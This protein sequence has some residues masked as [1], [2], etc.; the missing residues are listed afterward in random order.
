M[1][2]AKPYSL[3][4]SITITLY[5]FYIF[6]CYQ[7][8][9]MVLTPSDQDFFNC[10]QI[11]KEGFK[12]KEVSSGKGGL[13]YYERKKVNSSGTLIFFHGSGRS[14]CENSEILPNLN[15]LPF[16]IVMTEYPGYGL[17]KPRGTSSQNA[18]LASSLV[19]AKKIQTESQKNEPLFLYG[20]SMGSTVATYVASKLKITGL[21]LRNPPTS[22]SDNAEK[23]YPSILKPL[24]YIALKSDFPAKIWAKSVKAPVLILHAENDE[25]V[26]LAM[27]KSQAKNFVKTKVKFVTI[28]GAKHMNT[29]S[30]PEY[31]KQIQYFIKQHSK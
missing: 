2:I 27:G 26:P 5:A 23:I 1:K 12:V 8:E 16:N 18:I 21:I 31:K 17:G 22:I 3:I 25:W 14:A 30:F 20:A 24:I 13:R 29:F 6:A 28:E 7:I 15:S 10:P 9:K 11:L 4:I 19:L